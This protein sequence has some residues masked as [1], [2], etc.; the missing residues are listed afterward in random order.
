M[1][2][3]LLHTACVLH[4]QGSAFGQQILTVI[5]NNAFFAEMISY[6]HTADGSALYTTFFQTVASTFPQYL[7]ELRGMAD[8]ANVSFSKVTYQT[9]IPF[10]YLMRY[11]RVLM[12]I[13]STQVFCNVGMNDY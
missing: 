5:Q 4:M 9:A 11:L 13:Y 6:N 12:V 2:D 8:G 10:I 1:I 7:E 3:E